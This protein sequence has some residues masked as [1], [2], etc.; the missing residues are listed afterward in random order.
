MSRSGAHAT[1]LLLRVVSAGLIRLRVARHFRRPVPD[2]LLG[3]VRITAMLR[4]IGLYRALEAASMEIG[5]PA[6]H[7]RI[8]RGARDPISAP[9]TISPARVLARGPR[10]RLV[11]SV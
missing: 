6:L 7:L 9:A 11:T 3:D 5:A 8:V 2:G 1:P 10:S 4:H